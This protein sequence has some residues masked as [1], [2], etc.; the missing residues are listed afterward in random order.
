MQRAQVSES[1]NDTEEKVLQV[2]A[3]S[4]LISKFEDNVK[5]STYWF[6]L[7]DLHSMFTSSLKALGIASRTISETRL[8]DDIMG[9][10]FGPLCGRK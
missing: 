6:K 1:S 2:R 8:K 3:F 4:E 5:N 7:K 10:F 9:N